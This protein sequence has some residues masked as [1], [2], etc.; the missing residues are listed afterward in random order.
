MPSESQDLHTL[1]R[2]VIEIL[3]EAAFLFCEP[4]D[5]MNRTELSSEVLMAKLGFTGP[6]SG[7]MIF[8]APPE[9]ASEIAANLLGVDPDDP[10]VSGKGAE[11]VGEILNII[12][13]A[14]LKEW[15]GSSA[16]FEMGIPEVMKITGAE[17]EK[18]TAQAALHLPL[19]T[20]EGFRIDAAVIR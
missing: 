2:V 9:T 18:N 17:L 6:S 13:G 14:L 12:G 15:F 8:S 4:M 16:D 20:D 3:E 7:D 11:A 10:E 5:E 1:G 19:M